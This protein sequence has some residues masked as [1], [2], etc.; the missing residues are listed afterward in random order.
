M[1]LIGRMMQKGRDVLARKNY[2]PDDFFARAVAAGYARSGALVSQDNSLCVTA[3]LGCVRVVS[4]DIGK[5]DLK[6]FRHENN[7]LFPAV[8][9]PLYDLLCYEPNSWQTPMEFRECL[10]AFAMMSGNGIA[11]KT[12]GADGR[13]LELLPIPPAWYS[14]RRDPGQWDLTYTINFPN[15]A[16]SVE[17][18]RDRI[19]H[20]RG[21]SFDGYTGANII[22]LAREAIGLAMSGEEHQAR[23]AE[24]SLQAPG[25]LT[26]EN[27]LTKEQVEQIK[28]SLKETKGGVQNAGSTA[29][30]QNGVEYKELGATGQKAEIMAT[31]S[32]Q[33]EEVCR[34][35]RVFPQMIGYTD[36][37]ATHGSADS[38]FGA[39]VIHTLQPWSTRWEQAIMR[40]LISRD[41]RKTGLFA[42]LMLQDLLR[43][44]PAARGAFYKDLGQ[45]GAITPN[46][47]RIREGM[48]PIQ[49]LD[50]P[51][52]PSNMTPEDPDN[53]DDVDAGGG[54]PDL[55]DDNVDNGDDEDDENE[56]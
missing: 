14:I 24:G 27:T 47:V 17:V 43:G 9:H 15:G 37:T 48:N 41:D 33:V 19:F 26:T 35:F 55:A 29:L 46:E 51:L 53:D 22:R 42:K 39:H 10:T 56:T 13:V 44:D 28:A 49:G 32:F 25:Y 20:L 7:S 54:T 18:K 23:I 2:S 30:F 12:F 6:L 34:A 16:G 38:F 21:P 45:C 5:V 1:N 3:V 8:D 4:E 50:T 52:R 11:F 31:R 40:D 36:K